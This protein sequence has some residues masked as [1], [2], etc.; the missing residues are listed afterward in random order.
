MSDQ[1][2]AKTRGSYSIPETTEWYWLDPWLL[3]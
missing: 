2:A 1:K 3:T